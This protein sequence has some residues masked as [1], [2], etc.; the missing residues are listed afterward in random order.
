[1]PIITTKFHEILFSSFRSS[2]HKLSSKIV[3]FLSSK[4]HN[5]QENNPTRFYYRYAHLHI[6]S[7]IT[8]KFQEIPFSSFREEAITNCFSSTYF[9]C[10][11]FK[12]H[13]SQKNNRTKISFRHA[14]LHVM[15]LKTTMFQE[16]PFNSFRGESLTKTLPTDSRTGQKHYTLRNFVA[17]GI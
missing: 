9:E 7:I 2:A 10:S 17:W 8:T 5:S 15:S 14:H 13:N 4:G 16:I 11:K 3:N 12:G 1:M 6:M